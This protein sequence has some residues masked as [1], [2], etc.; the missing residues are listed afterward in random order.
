MIGV[1]VSAARRRQWEYYLRKKFK[2]KKKLER[3]VE[4]LVF[5]AVAEEAAKELKK[6]EEDQSE[7]V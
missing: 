6:I 5:E 4:A 3:L 2:S 7:S 1:K